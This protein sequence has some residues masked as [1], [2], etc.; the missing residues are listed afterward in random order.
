MSFL[1]RITFLFA[2]SV[3][4]LLAAP[5]DVYQN[6]EQFTYKVNWGILGGAAEIRISAHHEQKDNRPVVHL[7]IESRT[8]GVVRS[9]YTYNSRTDA[10]ID[11]ATGQLIEVR[12]VSGGGDAKS[13][14]LTRFDYTTMKGTHTDVLRPGRNREF[15]FSST[16]MTDLISC[17]VSTRTW[18]LPVG[19]KKSLQVFAGRDIYPVNVYAE[20]TEAVRTSDGKKEALVLIPRMESEP[21]RGVFKKG[22]IKV[23]ISTA[24]PRLPVKMQLQ[25]NFGTATL[26]LIKHEI[27]PK[28]PAATS[29]VASAN[30]R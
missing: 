27:A 6:G 16:E 3:S 23:W 5:F 8:N 28:P 9:L 7:I 24:E 2:M 22:E 17:L 11:Y 20:K 13:D 10:L 25:L 29:D 21:A 4:A 12:E 1:A 30:S 26:Q 15:T 14:S 18:Q 19:Q